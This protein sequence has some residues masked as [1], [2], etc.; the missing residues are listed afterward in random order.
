MPTVIVDDQSRIYSVPHISRSSGYIFP[1]RRRPS[2]AAVRGEPRRPLGRDET[3]A[4][5]QPQ[6]VEL[7]N[8]SA[9][10]I[11]HVCETW[12]WAALACA[13]LI[14]VGTRTAQGGVEVW[15]KHGL[16][17]R[18]ITALAIDPHIPSTLYAATSGGVFQSTNSGASWRSVMTGLTNTDVKALAIDPMAPST[19]YAGTWGGGVFQSTDSGA[20][21]SPVNTG[22]TANTNVNALAIDPMT[23]STLYAGT[24]G[25]GTFKSTNSGASWSPVNTGLYDAA[26]DPPTIAYFVHALAIDPA[27]P[28][29]LYAATEGGVFKSTDGGTRWSTTGLPYHAPLESGDHYWWFDALAIDPHIPSTLYVGT[30]GGGSYGPP[31]G[32]KSAYKSTDSGASWSV[33]DSG[34]T[35]PSGNALIVAAL[36]IDPHT[37]ST[38]YAATSGGVFQSTDSG[39]SW[40]SV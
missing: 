8:Q 35:D 23:P 18:D 13:G 37:P 27:T 33:V 20:S 2:D 19:L 16:Y 11:L 32:A 14:V 12:V 22:L 17:G 34:L 7:M 36:A 31:P 15:T 9:A 4:V 26:S 38:L 29:T 30:S 5:G 28:R 24:Q 3:E 21:W 25:D 39:A 10:G 6:E 1:R 40:S